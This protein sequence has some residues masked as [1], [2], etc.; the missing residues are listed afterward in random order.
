M[1]TAW[2]TSDL[3]LGHANIIKY[4]DRPWAT[5]DEMNAALIENWNARVADGDKVYVLGDLAMGK[6]KET[7]PLAS[8]LK[9]QKFLVPGNH[10]KCHPMHKKAGASRKMY[11][12]AG[13]TILPP[14][15]HFNDLILAHFPFQMDSRHDG[16]YAE[17]LTKPEGNKWLVHGHIH[18]E[19]RLSGPR[20][21][22]IGVDANDYRPVSYE[23]ILEWIEEQP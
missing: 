3:H 2:F 23:A 5:V 9:G 16:K 12:D 1:W 14:V 6:L 8:E 15:H 22:D 10:D 7:V 17:W 18:G 21:I 19:K 20:Q 11:M 13:F 4:T